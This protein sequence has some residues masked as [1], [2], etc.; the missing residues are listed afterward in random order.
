[1]STHILEA[2]FR[3]EEPELLHLPVLTQA[4]NALPA[5]TLYNLISAIRLHPVAARM[6]SKIL[7][8]KISQTNLNNGVNGIIEKYYAARR[9][10]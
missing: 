1:M 10:Y 8:E 5:M 3:G 4:F 7:C 6:A 2:C 9:S